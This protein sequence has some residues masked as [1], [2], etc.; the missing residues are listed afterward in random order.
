MAPTRLN[1]ADAGAAFLFGDDSAALA[2]VIGRASV[3]AEFVDRWR[4]PG[5]A[6][7]STWEERFGEQRYA[8][9]ATAVVDELVAAGTDLASITRFAVAGGNV[10][11]VRTVGAALARRTG[12][13]Q[14]GADLATQLGNGGAAQVGLVLADLLDAAEPGDRLLLVSLA[15]GA[16]ALLLEAGDALPVAARRAASE[17]G[18]TTACRS[19]TRSTWSGASGSSASG[20]GGPSRSGR[21]PRS[22]GATGT[23]SW[24]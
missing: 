20:R 6:E 8:E 1:G 7:G 10:R 24:P 3:T 19:T 13:Q 23:T 11:A 22:R 18:S 9:L 12:G 21:R 17:P 4:R 2:R 5:S 15:D 14:H 16:D